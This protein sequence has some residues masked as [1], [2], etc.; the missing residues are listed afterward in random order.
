M[1][2]NS[3]PLLAKVQN[4]TYSSPPSPAMTM[5]V[6]AKEFFPRATA[7]V[8]VPAAAP[9]VDLGELLVAICDEPA[10][11]I[12]QPAYERACVLLNSTE[13]AGE[14]VHLIWKISRGLLTQHPNDEFPHPTPLTSVG[15]LGATQ[16]EREKAK[17]ILRL[18]QVGLAEYAM[19]D[20][21]ANH[22]LDIVAF[23][24]NENVDM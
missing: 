23:I 18:P 14:L 10:P 15:S 17:H 20:E 24:A 11:F 9:P 3:H 22:V 2:A 19:H 1:E 13:G 16:V 7:P 8:S 6:H 5:N 4:A 21:Y 12:P